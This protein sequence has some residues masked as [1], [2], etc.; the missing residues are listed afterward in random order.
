MQSSENYPRLCRE[1]VRYLAEIGLVPV[2]EYLRLA[3]AGAFDPRPAPTVAQAAHQFQTPL[4]A[5]AQ[6]MQGI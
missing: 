2:R 1:T 5:Y 3:R 4:R 6:P